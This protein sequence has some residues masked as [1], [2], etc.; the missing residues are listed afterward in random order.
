MMLVPKFLYATKDYTLNSDEVSPYLTV[1]LN[2]KIGFKYI[3]L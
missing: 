1:L 2:V 3:E